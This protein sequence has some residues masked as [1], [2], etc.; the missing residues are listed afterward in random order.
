MVADGG[1]PSRSNGQ[2]KSVKTLD[3]FWEF[4]AFR[5]ECS[6]GRIVGFIWVVITPPKPSIPEEDEDMPS[7]LSASK[8]FLQTNSQENVSSP[9]RRK[10]SRRRQEAKTRYG[11]IPLVLPK[12]KTTYRNLPITPNMS[13]RSAKTLPE[14]SPYWRWPASSRGTIC[15][16]LKNYDRAHEVLLQQTFANRKAAARSTRKWKE[17]IAVLGGMDEWAF[18]VIGTKE[19]VAAVKPADATNSVTPTMVMGVRKKR[20]PDIPSE[21]ATKTEKLAEPAQILGEGTVRKKAK[22]EPTPITDASAA[23]GVNTLTAG[24]VRKKPKV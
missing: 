1:T 6:S 17:E 13:S 24:L 23:N 4:M 11:P 18:T 9:K 5:Q 19:Y 3:Q 7:Q 14:N 2:W 8:S 21:A 12:I 22:T 16:S 15:F 20:K 10:T